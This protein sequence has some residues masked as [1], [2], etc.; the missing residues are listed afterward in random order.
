MN[1]GERI[2]TFRKQKKMSVDELATKIGKNRATVYRY[3]KN[4]IEDLPYTVLIPIAK[5]LDVS[6]TELMGYENNLIVKDSVFKK[7]AKQL[8]I[9]SFTKEEEMEI[10]NYCK[11]IISKRGM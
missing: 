5:A 7:L 6:I 3:E 10:I 2:K 1:I 8:G 4:E 11:F 9:E